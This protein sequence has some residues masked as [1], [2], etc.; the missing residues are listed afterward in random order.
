VA[1]PSKARN[2]LPRHKA[3]QKKLYS[4]SQ[5][6]TVKR[7]ASQSRTQAKAET[8]PFKIISSVTDGVS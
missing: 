8:Q 1:E 3:A 6:S 2:F 7:D 5:T 4:S